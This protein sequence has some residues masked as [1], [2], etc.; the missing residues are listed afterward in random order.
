[1]ADHPLD[2][3]ELDKA[4]AARAEATS[5]GRLLTAEGQTTVALDSA[6][7]LVEHRPDGAERVIAPPSA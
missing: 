5:F 7:N 3:R 2:N 6:G 4:I 1:M